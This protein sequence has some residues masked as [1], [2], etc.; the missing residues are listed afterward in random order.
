MVQT[1][2][3]IGATCAQIFTSSPQQ[4]RAKQ[5]T[6]GEA[7]AFQAAWAE[8]GFGPIVAHDSYL[9]N[10]ASTDAE[11][12]EKSRRAFREEIARCGQLGLPIIVTH[13]GAYKGGTL[14]DGLNCLAASLNDL[15]PLAEEQRVQIVLETTAG[16][17]TYLGG[18][19]AQFPDLFARIPAQA[20]LGV[21]LDLCHV[22]VAGYDLRDAD[23]YARLWQ[24]F[25]D[26][27]GLDRL[28]VIHVNDTDRA[29]GS[30]S[31]RHAAIGKGIIGL[32]A[33]RLLMHDQRL[34]HIPKILETPVDDAAHGEEVALLKSLA[35]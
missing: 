33:F 17:G 27:I 11:I 3:G 2:L 28:Q 7:Q 4:W 18:V 8:S 15:I 30:H 5:Y 9:I 29:L 26:A 25:D 31:D 22:F 14:E 34:T 13:L 32:E 16:Q 6:D 10:L 21:C 24:E 1:S 35:L 12:L 20:K 23:S 19:F